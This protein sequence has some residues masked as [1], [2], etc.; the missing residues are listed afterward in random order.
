MSAMSVRN[1]NLSDF[2]ALVDIGLD[3]YT[4]LENKAYFN[5]PAEALT[6]ELV[7]AQTLIVES[8]GEIVSFLCYR[9]LVDEYEI[10]VL[11]TRLLSQKNNFQVSLISTLQGFAAK[12]RKS[13][14]L[15]VHSQNLK[16]IALYKKMSFILLYTRKQYYPDSGSAYVMVWKSQ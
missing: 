15:E 3:I 12:Q 4:S 5:W 16:A 11:A 8:K 14:I 10:T 13:I 7:K 6:Q 1:A 9:D 2:R